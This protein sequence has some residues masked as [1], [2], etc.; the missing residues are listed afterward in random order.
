MSAVHQLVPHL[1]GT[2]NYLDNPTLCSG[3]RGE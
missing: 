3:I 1:D 2:S